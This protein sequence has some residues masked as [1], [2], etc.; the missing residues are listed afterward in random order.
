MARAVRRLPR[1]AG[2]GASPRSA[3]GQLMTS[4]LTRLKR[5][6]ERLAERASTPGQVGS[7]LTSASDA[8]GGRE[9]A[10]PVSWG[11]GSLLWGALGG[12][13]TG[14]V[15]VATKVHGPDARVWGVFLACLLAWASFAAWRMFSTHEAAEHPLRRLREKADSVRQEVERSSTASPEEG[16]PAR[17][18][19]LFHSQ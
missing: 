15:V 13:A 18:A 10:I 14:A 9:L 17:P 4:V 1:R 8:L 6:L 3:D 16:A 7:A 2:A 19:P 5:G 11:L 12:V